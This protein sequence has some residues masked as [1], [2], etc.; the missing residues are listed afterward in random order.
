MNSPC[1]ENYWPASGPSFPQVGVGKPYLYGLCAG[2]SEGVIKVVGVTQLNSFVFLSTDKC[3]RHSRAICYDQGGFFHL[4][5]LWVKDKFFPHLLNSPVQWILGMRLI[6]NNFPVTLFELFIL[7]GIGYSPNWVGSGDGS[8]RGNNY[9][10]KQ[11][12]DW[13]KILSIINHEIC[14]SILQDNIQMTQNWRIER[15]LYEFRLLQWMN[16]RGGAQNWS[17]KTKSQNWV[18]VNSYYHT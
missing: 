9:W 12:S 15:L 7:A 16:W 14:R 6:F 5:F 18:N 8:S 3:K 13:L 2:G 17:G 11:W 1:V 10:R 4:G